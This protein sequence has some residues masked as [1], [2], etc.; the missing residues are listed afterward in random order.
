MFWNDDVL[1]R[2]FWCRNVG[3]M[4]LNSSETRYKIKMCFVWPHVYSVL[5]IPRVSPSTTYTRQF[6]RGNRRGAKGRYI[7]PSYYYR[8][9]MRQRSRVGPRPPAWMKIQMWRNDVPVIPKFKPNKGLWHKWTTYLQDI[10]LCSL[11]RYWRN[12][13]L[14][15]FMYVWSRY[16]CIYAVSYHIS[17]ESENMPML[18]RCSR[19]TL[20]KL[21]RVTTLPTKVCHSCSVLGMRVVTG[22]FHINHTEQLMELNGF[23]RW[24]VF[25]LFMLM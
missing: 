11:K 9:A 8:A 1:S 13:V 10:F 2:C 23:A 20:K 3:L 12:A 4:A 24:Q 22:K 17:A 14:L 21:N 19:I 25:V 5:Q 16:T 6:T 7:W 18:L 15:P